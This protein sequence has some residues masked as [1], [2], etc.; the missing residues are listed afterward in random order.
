MSGN[1]LSF[2]VLRIKSTFT[3]LA[4]GKN[5]LLGAKPYENLSS[6]VAFIDNIMIAAWGE[7]FKALSLTGE[8]SRH[9]G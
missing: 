8:Y 2:P 5:S 4:T 9:V 1:F 7:G 3:R 6:F